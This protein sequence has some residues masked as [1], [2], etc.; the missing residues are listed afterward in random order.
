MQVQ[1]IEADRQEKAFIE[2]M[3]HNLNALLLGIEE[4]VTSIPKLPDCVNGIIVI[5]NFL[6]DQYNLHC[7]IEHRYYHTS[8][9]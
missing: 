9:H 6:T 1:L 2:I 4:Y 5:K 3:T 8:H 7:I